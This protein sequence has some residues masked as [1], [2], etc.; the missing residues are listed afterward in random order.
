MWTGGF[1]EESSVAIHRLDQLFSPRRIAI[2][3]VSPNPE[4]VGGRLLTNLIGG[5]RGVVYPVN[6]TSEAVLGIPCFSDLAAL[7]NRPDLGVICAAA[8]Q[9]PNLVRQCGEAGVLAL[10]IVSA[11]F[12]EIGPSGRALEDRI[13]AERRRFSGMRILG[14]NCLGFIVPHLNLNVSFANG[15]PKAGDIAFISQSGALCSSVLDWAL[16]ENVGFSYFISVG[17]ALDVDFGDLIDF[18]GEDERTRSIV[19]YLESVTNARKFM[20]AARAFART[21]PIVAYKAGRFPESAAAA[22][23]H[24]GAMAAADDVYAAAFQRAGIARIDR[25]G[26][27]F[28]VVDLIGRQRKPRGPRLAVVTNAGGPGVIATDA[29]IGAGGVLA[30]LREETRAQLDEILP[31]QWSHGNPVDVLGDARSKRFARA[32]EIVAQDSGVDA[33]LVIVTPQAMTNPTSIAKA[34]GRVAGEI[35]QPI[36]A[37]WLGGRSMAEG[38]EALNEAGV[39]TFPTPEQAVQAFMTLMDYARNLEVLYE[40]PRE[41]NVSLPVARAEL[42]ERYA[43]LLGDAQ[44]TLGEDT[45]KQLL[46]AYGIPVTSPQP[47]ATADEAVAAAQTIGYPVV[48]KVHSP[49]ITHKTDVG[50][51]MLDL[52]DA[53]AVRAAF[54]RIIGAA[55]THA[56]NARLAGVTVQPQVRMRHGVELILGTRRD[57]VFGSVI[58]VGLGGTAAEL[59]DDRAIGFPPLNER[60]ARRMLESLK[61][62][63][64]LSGYRGR[65]TLAVERLLEILFRLSYLVVDFPEIAELDVNPLLIGETDVVA[66]D[67]RVIL[68][69]S[70]AAPSAARYAH[71]A[72]RPYPEEYVRQVELDGGLHVT[73]RPIKPE[74]E[75]LWF[76]LLRNCSR[77]TLYQRFRYLFHWETHDIATR[78]C[79][80]D[81]DREIAIVAEA[82]IEGNRQLLGVGR[83]T[84][85]PDVQTVEFAVLVADQWQDRGLGGCL[86][87]YCLEISK[88]WGL[89]RVIAQTTRDN[90]RMLAIFEK[91]GFSAQYD[92]SGMEV[93]LIKELPR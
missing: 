54:A 61:I 60:L 77:E 1:P 59:F 53:E 8:E 71:L 75:P 17:N 46:A 47:C 83:L 55:R 63:P 15:R 45:A 12:R 90:A 84:A 70:G 43:A 30:G 69:S 66:L 81:Y 89:A 37:A 56:P 73:L 64:L 67:A 35:K 39:A 38:I 34:V 2:L 79:F 91:R 65:P 51:V 41:I 16:S 85:D 7:P 6:P 52:A 58:M 82:Q 5:F 24:T 68:D 11:G 25:I 74:D 3:G 93:E 19:L 49:D 40:T 36:L 13:E 88:R 22:A 29:L 87:D 27:I 86:T 80:I 28:D 72:L 21:K 23:S 48:M 32:I 26:D 20:T 78:Y 31:P 18:L 44:T 50:G 57:P 42:R 92:A 10:V 9:V 14:P 33:I 76:D 62:W 4:S